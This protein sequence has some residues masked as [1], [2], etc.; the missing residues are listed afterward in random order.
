MR[1]NGIV[2]TDAMNME[3]SAFRGKGRIYGPRCRV[4][5]CPSNRSFEVVTSLEAKNIAFDEA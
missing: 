5:L 3:D 4:D 2:I 1:F